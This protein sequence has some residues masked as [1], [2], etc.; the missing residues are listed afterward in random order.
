LA[1]SGDNYFNLDAYNGKL[2]NGFLYSGEIENLNLNNVELVVL[3]ACE[4][5]IANNAIFATTR[6]II[7]SLSKAG[8]K[9]AIVSL[10]KV[11]DNVTKEFMLCFYKNLFKNLE[12]SKALREAKLEI[13]KIHPEPYFWAPF[14]LYQLN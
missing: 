8:A 6:G 12:I 1:F 9:N 13:K 11:D 7:N 5:G 4:S 2:E 10:W 3:S 14:V